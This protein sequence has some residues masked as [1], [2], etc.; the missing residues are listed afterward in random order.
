M[1]RDKPQKE[2]KAASAAAGAQPKSSMHPAGS[3]AFANAV[4][5]DAAPTHA[6]PLP[7]DHAEQEE[8]SF[9]ARGYSSPPYH[10]VDDTCRALR[11][12][13][14]VD[15]HRALMAACKACATRLLTHSLSI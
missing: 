11:A 9:E 13:W 3:A 8:S 6:R 7:K 1:Q 14:Q 12:T 10:P 15:V 5:N 4:F 2:K